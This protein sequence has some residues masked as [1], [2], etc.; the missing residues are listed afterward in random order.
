[1]CYEFAKR[2]FNVIL[3]G[4][5]GIKKVEKKIN[6]HLKNV[7][8]IT[9]IT[10]FCKAYQ[11]NYF[12]KIEYIL[13]NLDGELSMLVNNVGHRTGWNPYHEMPEQKINDTIICGTIVQSRM[14]QIAIKH[15]EKRIN[16][17][18]KSGIINITSMCMNTPTFF[19]M[20]THI[21]V[22]YCSV[23]DAANAFGFF[24]SNSIQKE[25]EKTIDILNITPGA[26]I[27]NNTPY[28]KDIHF[29]IDSE[30]FVKNIFKLIG[31]YTGPQYAYWLHEI[32]AILYPLC[33][34]DNTLI[35]VG[36]LIADEYMFR[37]KY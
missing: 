16:K 30:Q 7:K 22:P 13:D 17:D 32:S 33:N 8:T 34:L 37:F 31:N 28:L 21:S 12:K 11:K 24:H 25:Y 3:M 14:T 29:S 6:Q 27:T 1:M 18:Y 23:Y 20:K 26:V 5:K 4:Y 15:F 36:K 35:K 10:D 9:Y 19:N 2:N